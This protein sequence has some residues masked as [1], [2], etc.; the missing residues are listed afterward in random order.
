MSM[1]PVVLLKEQHPTAHLTPE[2]CASEII[3]A[4]P[5]TNALP[6][7]F[8]TEDQTDQVLNSL[9]NMS[10]GKMNIANQMISDPPGIQWSDVLIQQPGESSDMFNAR[11]ALARSIKE[12]N[13]LGIGF[14][15]SVVLAGILLNRA[16]LGTSY[17]PEVEE[18]LKV[19]MMA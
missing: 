14:K 9:I 5:A 16:I 3:P 2:Q 4:N 12:K 7:A 19:L 1:P 11:G 10:T 13:N 6:P 15:G 17:D 18:Y 8:M